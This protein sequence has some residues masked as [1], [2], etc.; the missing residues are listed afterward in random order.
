MVVHTL[1]T[2]TGP[3]ERILAL[4]GGAV[5]STF[6]DIR[7]YGGLQILLRALVGG[8]SMVLS[9]LREPLADYLGRVAANRVTH[10][11]GTPSHWRRALMS[12]VAKD[13]SPRYVRMSGE[14]ADQANALVAAWLSLPDREPSNR[15]AN[16]RYLLSWRE[17]AYLRSLSS[18]A[19]RAVGRE[20]DQGD[21]HERR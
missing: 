3:V 12:P 2:L 15:R 16:T 5:W 17:V 10:I 7:R 9:G 8:G 13:I 18:A 6:Y 20:T 4:G 14:V 11:S 1:D 19:S 21:R